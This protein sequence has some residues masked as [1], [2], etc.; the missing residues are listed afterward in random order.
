MI[1]VAGIQKHNKKSWS[2]YQRYADHVYDEKFLL[3]IFVNEKT[4]EQQFLCAIDSALQVSNATIENWKHELNYVSRDGNSYYLSANFTVPRTGDYTIEVVYRNAMEWAWSSEWVVD[5]TSQKRF[6]WGSPEFRS[7]DVSHYHFQQGTHEFKMH[8]NANIMVIGIVVKAITVYRAD[9]T[10]KKENRLT[11]IKANHK[12]TKQIG[13]DELSVV[14][15]YDSAYSDP[16]SLTN[17]I[18]DYRDEVNFHFINNDGEMEQVFGGYVSSCS[19]SSNETE[20]TIN[21]AGRLIDGEKRYIVEEMNVGGEAS[22]LDENYPLEYIRRFENYNDA[23][24]YL[25]N[26]Y[27]QP[28]H[29]NIHD[30]ISAKQYD[31]IPFD[32]TDKEHFDRCVAENLT[33][34]LMPTGVY[35]RNGAG[36][37]NTQRLWIYDKDWYANTD[38]ILLDDFPV[39]Y[40]TY[41]MGEAVT[42]LEVEQAETTTD[43][44]MGVG[45]GVSTG[46]VITTNMY[47]TCGCCGGTVP[48]QRYQ[49]SWKNYCPN[50]GKSGTLKDTPKGTVDGELTC[51]MSLGGCDADYCGYCGGDKWGGGKCHWKKLTPASGSEVSGNSGDSTGVSH[52]SENVVEKIIQTMLKYNYGDG[53][54]TLYEMR[55]KGYGNYKAFSELIYSELVDMGV[56]A[57]MVTYTKQTNQSF[58]S[59][60]VKNKEEEYV[61]FPY[62]SDEIVKHFGDVLKP[63]NASTSA[64][65]VW[66]SDGLGIDVET[67]IIE[68]TVAT[69]SGFDKDKPFKAYIVVEYANSNGKQCTG[70]LSVHFDTNNELKCKMKNGEGNLQWSTV[71][72]DKEFLSNCKVTVDSLW[73][74]VMDFLLPNDHFERVSIT[75]GEGYI[76]L[77]SLNDYHGTFTNRPCVNNL[78]TTHR[79]T[80]IDFTAQKPDNYM[81]WSGL[82]PL[83]LNNII[84]TSSVN[85]V[86][87]MR[88]QEDTPHVYLHKVYFEYIVGDEALWEDSEENTD[89]SSNRMILREL[90]FRNGSLL[91]P[92]DLGSTG[93]TVNSVIST[94]VD[95][96]ELKAKFY[97]STHRG[98]DKII[99]SKDKSFNPSFT[100]DESKNVLAISNWSFNPVNDYIDRSVVVYKNKMEDANKG[101]VYNYT[102]SRDREG[103]MRYGEINKLTSLSDDISE[104]EAYYNAKKEFKN[105]VGD[106]MTVTVFGCPPNLHIGDY[107]ECLFEKSVY[108][109]V[110]EVA[111]IEREFDIKQAPH[112]Q[113]K[114]GLN[115]PDPLLSLKQKF[116]NERQVAREHKTLF[117]RTA[118]Y[119]DDVYTWEE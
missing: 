88:E 11:L 34:E 110:K 14:I 54:T 84:N 44:E 66:E 40:I 32:V 107:V 53:V 30:I 103:L 98:D 41:G 71:D 60:L 16:K 2:D 33:K 21:C 51:S 26:N 45:D 77:S 117:S 67:G 78:D 5:G 50:C 94:V 116:E 12:V 89:N 69:S 109:D 73:T 91:N 10:L 55:K 83:C 27:E 68:G 15:L 18:F 80:F 29:S 31:N 64:T 93:K 102:E 59:V 72:Y 6:M 61:D 23:L 105:V 47:P 58:Y 96:G 9:D 118:I 39:F 42:T 75:H 1:N 92:V 7:R 37:S 108:N 74:G 36:A 101:A 119:D 8:F 76:D 97:P 17:Y 43:S 25:F 81:T 57:K 24:E 95:N 48:Y 112:I 86:D 90:G 85:I 63:T 20:L 13:A 82:T 19:L 70:E 52:S 65:V 62:Q 22:N 46:G 79:L 111:S 56:G 28:L 4:F 106:S 3:E 35:L 113:T 87:R 38:P 104:Q 100:V 49:R 115:R 99:L 114:L